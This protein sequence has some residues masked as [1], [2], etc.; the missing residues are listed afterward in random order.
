MFRIRFAVVAIV[1]TGSPAVAEPLRPQLGLSPSQAI[2]KLAMLDAHY[3]SLTRDEARLFEQVKNSKFDRTSFAEACLIAASV[4]DPNTRNRYLAR[5]DSLE[6]DARKAT[7][8]SKSVAQDGRVLLR[9]LHT[10]PMAKGYKAEQTDLHVLLDTGEFNCVSSAALYTVLG[11]RL[12][13]DV[14]SVETPKHVF[15]ILVTRDRKIDVETTNIRGF[16]VDPKWRDGPSKA[17][18]PTEDRREVGPAGLA[19]V[20]AF[21]H[22]VNLGKDKQYSKSIRAYLVAIGLDSDN[23]S[24][25]NNLVSDLINWPIEIAKGGDYVKTMQVLA[26]AREL[27][28]K[29]EKLLHNTR[30]LY[31]SWAKISIDRKDW[32]N[33]IR[34]YEQALRELPGDTHLGDNLAYCRGQLR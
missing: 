12:G 13:I 27:A 1:F 17:D 9:F 31:D 11:Q 33:A 7:A 26:F 28:P 6:A 16:D 3:P 8:G 20:I 34:I 2:E 23:S 21:N 5:L 14:R 22:G 25:A 18:R 32:S 4:A 29:E 10:G 15:S 19:A 24:A 30:A